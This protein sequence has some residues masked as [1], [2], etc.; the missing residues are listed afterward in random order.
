MVCVRTYEKETG[1]GGEEEENEEKEKKMYTNDNYN[2][3][4]HLFNISFNK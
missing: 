1:I 4:N 3:L 2:L